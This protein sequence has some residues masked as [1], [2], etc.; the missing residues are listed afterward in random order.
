M[1]VLSSGRQLDSW[2]G[3]EGRVFAALSYGLLAITVIVSVFARGG[4]GVATLLDFALAAAAAAWMLWMVTLHPAWE[5]APAA[6]G[7]LFHRADRP[8]GGNGHPGAVVR[9][10]RVDRIPPARVC[11]VGLCASGR[12]AAGRG[13]AVAIVT[14][15][16]QSGGVPSANPGA[17][18]YVFHPDRGQHRRRRDHD[19]VRAGRQGAGRTAQAGARRA[20]GGEPQTRSLTSGERRAACP[21]PDAGAGGGHSRRA[22]AHGAGDPRHTGAG[23]HG[24]HR[25]TRSRQTGAPAPGAVADARRPGATAGAGESRRGA[26]VGAGAATG[27]AG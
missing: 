20:D 1:N 5:R 8:D 14:A 15:T 27:T 25:P 26:P 17:I 9:V 23:L 7:L 4:I 12:L 6:D 21:T 10:L 24:D 22:A 18:A 11:T 3:R 19:L 13:A 16:S 2:E